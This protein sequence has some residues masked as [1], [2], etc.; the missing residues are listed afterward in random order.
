MLKDLPEIYTEGRLKKL[1]NNM[2]GY[3]RHRKDSTQR[4]MRIQEDQVMR[5]IYFYIF[6]IFFDMEKTFNKRSQ[7][8]ILVKIADVTPPQYQCTRTR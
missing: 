1:F 3:Q 6:N 2:K 7:K 5:L 8:G 4:A